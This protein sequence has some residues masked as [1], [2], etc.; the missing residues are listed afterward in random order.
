VSLTAI[1]LGAAALAAAP[2]VAE[3][4]WDRRVLLISAPSHADRALL[5]QRAVFFGMEQAAVERDLSIVSIAGET[6]IGAADTA[7]ALRRRYRLPDDRF[8]V[9]LLG[10]DGGLKLR[11]AA[12]V[13]AAQ[14]MGVID[15]MPMRRA[16]QR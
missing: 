2:M 1:L 8:A 11:A 12:P 4:Q 7:A 9:V 6:V 10:K 3:M 14:L 13:S 16:E 5:A 15:A